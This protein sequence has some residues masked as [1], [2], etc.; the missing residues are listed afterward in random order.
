MYLCVKDQYPRIMKFIYILF[1]LVLS[2]SVKAQESDQQLAFTYYQNKDYD[3]AAQIFLKIYERTRSS[4]FLDYHIICLINGKQYEQAEETL[5]KLLKTDE[6]NKDFMVK[7]G[8]IYEQQGKTKK[9]EEYYEK[10]IKLLI[11]HSSDINNLAY[12]FRDI[13]AY[14]WAIKTYLKG[15]ELLKQ[16]NA[17]T[18][19]LGDNYMMERN[20]DQM[21][22][23]FFQTLLLQPGEIN[24]IISKL[25]YA[26]SYDIVNNVDVVLEKKLE[27]IF[28]QKEYSPVFDELG[29]WYTLQKKEYPQALQHATLLNQK[30]ADKLYIYLNIARGAASTSNYQVASEAYGKILEKGKEGNSLYM[31]ARKEILTCEFQKAQEQ[32]AGQEKYVQLVD[33]CNA[34]LQEYKYTPENTDIAILLSDLYAY[35]LHQADS[36]NRILE[37]ST[38]IPRLDLN[39]L[40]LLKSKR[41]DL[42]TFMD[43]PWEATILYT[44]IEKSNPNNDISYEAKLKKA[45]LAYYAGD[46]LWAKAQFDVLKGS[47]TKLISNDAIQMSHFINMNYKEDE[48]NK[49]MVRL[50]QAEFLIYRQQISQALPILDSLINNS[51]VGIADYASLQK[52]RIFSDQTEYIKAVEILSKLKDHSEQTYIRAEA[53]FELANT[54]KQLK[55]YTEAKELYKTLVSEYSGSV[56]SVEAARR[57]R[58]MEKE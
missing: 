38:T 32:K 1:I 13:R 36:A 35:Q 12:R 10:T 56:Y 21:L 11:P 33:A 39:T 14:E 55:K 37:K 34:Y 16:P 2:L 42:L 31:T 4:T 17:F 29:V 19:E 30:S 47:T 18:S 45:Q 7:L 3:K 51:P 48:D 8:Y 50:A 46:L 49:D 58:E 24:N 53:I 23:L 6:Q 22:H 44:Q 54:Q 40:C 25:S 28:R 26:R 9:A 15:R 57:F 52:A 43:N 27:E 41:A 20:Y 5:K